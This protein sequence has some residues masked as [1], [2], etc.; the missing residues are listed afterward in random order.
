MDISC[1][2][3][4]HTGGLLRLAADGRGGG[5]ALYGSARG[6]A[7]GDPGAGGCGEFP[8]LPGRNYAYAGTLTIGRSGHH[9]HDRD[10]A[11]VTLNRLPEKAGSQS[12]AAN[13]NLRMAA[14]LAAAEQ[15]R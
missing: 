15:S 2:D 8:G 9:N 5:H 12:K 3:A 13:V 6:H 1:L 10:E 4:C 14:S 7:R 11:S